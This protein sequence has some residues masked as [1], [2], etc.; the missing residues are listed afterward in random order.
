VGGTISRKRESEMHSI[1][2]CS[3]RGKTRL[4]RSKQKLIITS[5][6]N[7]GSYHR[8]AQ[9]EAAKA[10]KQDRRSDVVNDRRAAL[11]DRLQSMKAK[12]DETMAMFRQM[13][14]S[15]FGQGGR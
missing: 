15:K 5:R 10:R 14:Q 9:R 12:D 13:A 8:L 11:S 1:S 3:Q 6:S 7:S 2:A 4:G